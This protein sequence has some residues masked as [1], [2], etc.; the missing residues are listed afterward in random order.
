MLHLTK[1]FDLRKIRNS[2]HLKYSN[3]YR[4]YTV[5]N[6]LIVYAIIHVYLYLQ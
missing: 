6:N 5:Y 2:F 1:N 3:N 4:V